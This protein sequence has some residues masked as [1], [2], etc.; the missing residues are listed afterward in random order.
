VSETVITKRDDKN[1]ELLDK[2]MSKVLLLGK[3]G[4][5]GKF[6]LIINMNEGGITNPEI[7]ISP[8]FNYFIKNM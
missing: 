8:K 6:K 2:M 1:K 7:C 3:Q 5:T 4:Y